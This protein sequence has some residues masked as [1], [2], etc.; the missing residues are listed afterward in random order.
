MNTRC[1]VGRQAASE[2]EAGEVRASPAGTGLNAEIIEDMRYLA[3]STL[4][5][6]RAFWLEQ[7]RDFCSALIAQG[8]EQVTA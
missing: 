4:P 6:N 3:Y 2:A 1:Q 5:E 8:F 7:L